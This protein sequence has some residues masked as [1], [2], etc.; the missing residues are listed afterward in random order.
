[1]T[2]ELVLERSVNNRMLMFN[3]RQLLFSCQKFGLQIV[4]RCICQSEILIDL[5]EAK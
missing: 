2:F 5:T 1:M 4:A 3:F